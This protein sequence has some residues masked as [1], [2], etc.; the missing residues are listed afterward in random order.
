MPTISTF[1][2][3]VI[4]VYFQQSEHN[5]PHVH[6]MYG[7]RAAALS[8]RTLEVLDGSLPTKALHM[9]REWVARWRGE[10]LEMWEGQVFRRLPPLE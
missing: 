5:P 9:A 2:G 10:L 3:L 8:I 1:Y 6:V 7:D 4:K